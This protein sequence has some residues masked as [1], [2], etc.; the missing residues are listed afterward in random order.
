MTNRLVIRRGFGASD[1]GGPAEAFEAG[2][3]E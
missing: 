3:Y 2:H 1:A